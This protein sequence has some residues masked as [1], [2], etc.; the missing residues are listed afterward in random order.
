MRV[1]QDGTVLRLVDCIGEH[2]DVRCDVVPDPEGAEL[3]LDGLHPLSVVIVSRGG[4]WDC[5]MIMSRVGRRTVTF[6]H[7][8]PRLDAVGSALRVPS[9]KPSRTLRRRPCPTVQS[10]TDVWF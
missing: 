7:A 4:L 5:G 9:L 6:A 2:G 3:A 1:E 8:G 10:E